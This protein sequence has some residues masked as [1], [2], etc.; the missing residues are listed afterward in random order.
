[1]V[2]STA[3]E[4]RRTGN[5]TVGSKPTLSATSHYAISIDWR[6]VLLVPAYCRLTDATAM[7][8]AALTRSRPEVR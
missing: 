1:V 3:L 8:R 2:E 6:R 7:A 4:M 5:R